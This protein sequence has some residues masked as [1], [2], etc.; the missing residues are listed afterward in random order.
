VHRGGAA[1]HKTL[2]G[3]LRL[4]GEGNNLWV[5]KQRNG[6]AIS[7]FGVNYAELLA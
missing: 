6:Y 3:L 5:F 7:L 2:S 1:M 4:R